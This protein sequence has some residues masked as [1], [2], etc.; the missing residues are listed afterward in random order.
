M[1][2]PYMRC[3]SEEKCIV[4]RRQLACKHELAEGDQSFRARCENNVRRQFDS[5]LCENPLQSAKMPKVNIHLCSYIDFFLNVEVMSDCMFRVDNLMS[6]LL[7]THGSIA[8]SLCSV[9]M[10]VVGQCLTPQSLMSV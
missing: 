1:L 9:T 7:K 3:I 4:G 5:L 6:N 8:P 10:T 2:N